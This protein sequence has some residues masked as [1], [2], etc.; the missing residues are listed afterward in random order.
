[1]LPRSSLIALRCPVCELVERMAWQ[2][3]AKNDAR[4]HFSSAPAGLHPPPQ[5]GAQGFLGYARLIP[6]SKT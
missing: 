1:M 4:K 3:V 6:W 2:G 5:R